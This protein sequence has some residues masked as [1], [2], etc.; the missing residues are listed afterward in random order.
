MKRVSVTTLEKFRRMR[1]EVSSYDTE[2]AF[3]ESIKTPFLG[4]EYTV[5]GS[6]FHHIVETGELS[7][8]GIDNNF[9]YQ[10]STEDGGSRNMD[11]FLAPEHSQMAIDY[12]NS[13]FEPAHEIP[14]GAEFTDMPFPI[15]VS[16]RIDIV[17]GG[18]DIADL[19]TSYSSKKYEDYYDS[20]QWRL[21]LMLADADRFM[22]DVFE[23]KDYKRDKHGADVRGLMLVQTPTIECLRYPDM[24]QSCRMLIRDFCE[25][26]LSRGLMDYLKDK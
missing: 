2:Q 22:Y 17:L 9:C 11:V 7:N 12:R 13:L 18:T 23:F 25:F 19:K 16:G 6:A 8:I 1:D 10:V 3:I 5:I 14:V 26:I 15:Y 24:E 21:Y 20:Y 4:N